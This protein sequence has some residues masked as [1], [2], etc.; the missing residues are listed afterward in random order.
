MARRAA[1][2]RWREWRR[3]VRED[4]ATDTDVLTA[5][6]AMDE[7]QAKAWEA[8]PA[9]A[10]MAETEP[11]YTLPLPAAINGVE[12]RTLGDTGANVSLVDA[13]LVEELSLVV[14]PVRFRMAAAAGQSF[15]VEG[16][17]HVTVTLGGVDVPVRLHVVRG[18]GHDVI[19][20][21]DY[22]SHSGVGSEWKWSG[23]GSVSL[24]LDGGATVTTTT[25]PVSSYVGGDVAVISLPP[26]ET[27]ACRLLIM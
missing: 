4:R 11:A 21:T 12:V 22:F 14:Q 5:S 8:L 17:A 2:A 9:C 26:S 27:H 25:T 23:D 3:L 18:L 20:G 10:T 13:R 7:E 16:A 19:L 15:T 24:T 1:V 6:S